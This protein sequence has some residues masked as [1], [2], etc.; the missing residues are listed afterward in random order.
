MNP[1]FAFVL[2]QGCHLIIYKC[3]SKHTYNTELLSRP[4]RCL[5]SEQSCMHCKA[6]YQYWMYF[7]GLIQACNCSLLHSLFSQ[8]D[9]VNGAPIADF[10]S[11]VNCKPQCQRM[12]S[13][14]PGLGKDHCCHIRA[15]HSLKVPKVKSWAC[16]F[17]IS[18]T[19]LDSWSPY[20]MCLYQNNQQDQGD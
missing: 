1:A 16:S 9:S 5:I 4:G 11:L 3:L 20:V 2:F 14:W 10:S 6:C 13:R 18:R 12:R 8:A 17:V 19:N 7:G 15:L